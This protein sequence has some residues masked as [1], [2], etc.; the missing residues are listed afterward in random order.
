MIADEGLETIVI[1]T[2]GSRVMATAGRTL[3]EEWS[4]VANRGVWERLEGLGVAPEEAECMD[5][6]SSLS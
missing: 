6:R 2:G 1:V 3:V 4:G 5:E